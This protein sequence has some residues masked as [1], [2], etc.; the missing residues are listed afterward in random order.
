MSSAMVGAWTSLGR[1]D[2]SASNVKGVSM[3]SP[4]RE[5]QIRD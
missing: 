3:I 4:Y 2:D 5:W 1:I